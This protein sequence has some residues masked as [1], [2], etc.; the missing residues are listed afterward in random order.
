MNKQL[1]AA[2][3][4]GA[5]VSIQAAGDL[6]DLRGL[7]LT[8]AKLP[9]YNKQV[10][11]SMVFCDKIGTYRIEDKTLDEIK[12]LVKKVQKEDAE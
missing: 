5:A 7:I 9:L 4:T 1:W 10:L 2:L 11:Q 12:E 8:N 3:L 6:E